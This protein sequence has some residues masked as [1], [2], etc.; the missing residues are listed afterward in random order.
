M[1]A[2][3]PTE[4]YVVVVVVVVPTYPPTHLPYIPSYHPPVANHHLHL[5]PP[6][7]LL[8]PR[9]LLSPSLLFSFECAHVEKRGKERKVEPRWSDE[10]ELL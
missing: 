5:F 4:Y 2:I 7:F 3:L 6:S 10:R 9:S 1:V 8:S